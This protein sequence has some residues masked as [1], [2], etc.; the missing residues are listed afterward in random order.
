MP[1]GIV[2]RA[3]RSVTA[4]D[5]PNWSC[6]IVV[7]TC[8]DERERLLEAPGGG[9]AAGG[10]KSLISDA[11]DDGGMS[12]VDSELTVGSVVLIS[13]AVVGTSV[14][15]VASST[16]ASAIAASATAV[17]AAST[18]SVSLITW[19]SASCPDSGS[20]KDTFLSALK[21]TSNP[22]SSVS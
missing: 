19:Y 14:T 10:T 11:E 15:A 7:V 21:G 1:I 16:P 9:T 6:T 5:T 20:L 8:E 22:F 17:T 18:S 4:T 13:A 3:A 12:E 2:A